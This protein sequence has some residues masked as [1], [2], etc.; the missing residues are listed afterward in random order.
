MAAFN[1]TGVVMPLI[2]RSPAISKVL[3]PVAVTSVDAKAI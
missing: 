2:V 1:V 3:S